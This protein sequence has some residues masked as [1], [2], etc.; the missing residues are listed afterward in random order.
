MSLETLPFEVQEMILRYAVNA[1][2]D[3]LRRTD[4]NIAYTV[5][6]RQWLH[7]RL[8]SKTFDNMLSE[9]TFEGRP[10]LPLLKGKQLEKLNFVLEAIQLTAD[11]PPINT[12]FSVPKIKRLCGKFWHNP[13]LSASSVRTIASLLQSPQSLNFAVKLEPWILRHR[14]RSETST[15][16]KD[17]VLFFDIG[18]W[19]VD[20]GELRIRRV[21]RWLSTARTRIGMYLTNELGQPVTPVH[22]RLGHDRRWY[23]EYTTG[24]GRDVLNCMV[25]FK[26]KMVWD[27]NARRLYDFEGQR[28]ELESQVVSEDSEED[29]DESFSELDDE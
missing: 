11:R 10:L 16:S 4:S 24:T 15:T 14:K 18:D 27:N 23:L 22:V 12:H 2:L 6:L 3:D 26:T 1:I 13:D 29:T 20:A 8:C 5:R 21:S 9:M 25:N 19:V 28:Y 7:L 17:G